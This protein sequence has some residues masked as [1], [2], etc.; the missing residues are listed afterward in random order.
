[1]FPASS[2]STPLMFASVQ[3]ESQLGV[4]EEKS[5]PSKWKAGQVSRRSSLVFGESALRVAAATEKAF[6]ERDRITRLG[7]C[8]NA[9]TRG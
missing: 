7:V 2:K 8:R 3:R 9:E 4:V 5:G 1:M 6:G